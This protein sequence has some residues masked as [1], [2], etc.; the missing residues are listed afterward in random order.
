[1]NILCDI[2]RGFPEKGIPDSVVDLFANPTTEREDALSFSGLS[3]HEVSA[4]NWEKN[5]DSIF[6]FTPEAF[7]YYLPSLLYVSAKHPDLW[8][9]A[10][11][12]F[13]GLLDISLDSIESNEFLLARLGLLSGNQKRI[14][15]D[16]MLFFSNKNTYS[17]SSL[18]RAFDVMTALSAT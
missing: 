7:K 14:V 10:A 2:K 17:P 18:G 4:E 3:W 8:L 13:I 6:F 15:V 11:D 5:P 12:A 16:W 1:M 9:R